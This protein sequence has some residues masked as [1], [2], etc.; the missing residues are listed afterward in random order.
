MSVSIIILKEIAGF[1]CEAALS[2]VQRAAD[3]A[4]IHC[5]G[6]ETP[7]HVAPLTG[8][9]TEYISGALCE[10]SAEE[11]KARFEQGIDTRQC[12]FTIQ[13]PEDNACDSFTWL[14]QKKNYFWALDLEYLGGDF[15]FAFRFLSQYFRL[16]ENAR[17]YLWIDD[18]DWFYTAEEI[19]QLS[20]GPYDQSWPYKKSNKFSISS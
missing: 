7:R 9:E 5:I 1:S 20:E 3:R 6:L 8:A 15:E 18:T 2:S 4:G 13:G 12:G 10:V 17:D 19:I 14:I 11:L 16:P